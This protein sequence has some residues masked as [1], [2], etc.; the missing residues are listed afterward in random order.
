MSA[1]GEFRFTLQEKRDRD[2][3]LYL[4]AGIHWLNAV[5]FIRQDP[6]I[7]GRWFASLKPY[8]PNG[9]NDD[10]LAWNSSEENSN[11]NQDRN[12]RK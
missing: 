4:F 9:N 7:Q 12:K 3:E 6:K 10:D 1:S 5:L 11:T 8:Q 2:G